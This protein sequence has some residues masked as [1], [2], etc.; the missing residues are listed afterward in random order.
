M[1]RRALARSMSMCATDSHGR[2]YVDEAPR[3]HAHPASASRDVGHQ[4]MHVRVSSPRPIYTCPRR[5][6]AARSR[7]RIVAGEIVGG[8]RSAGVYFIL[9]CPRDMIYVD[10][11]LRDTAHSDP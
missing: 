8:L 11:T 2:I 1:L 4:S 7:V 9:W 6:F 3:D 10:A 5:S